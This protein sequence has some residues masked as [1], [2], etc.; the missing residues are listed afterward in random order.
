MKH[1]PFNGIDVFLAI[2]RAGSLRAAAT[3]LGVGAPAVS[4]QLK[5]LEQTLG[6]SLLVRTTRSIKLTDAGRAL[7]DGAAPA[8]DQITEAIDDARETGGAKKGTIRLT[9]PWSAY[10]IV[11]APSLLNFQ[12]AYPDI[13]LEL[14]FN[15]A[16][17]DIV[18]GGFHAGIRLGDRLTTDMIAVRLTPPLIAAYSAAPEYLISAGTPKH[19]RDLLHHKCIRYRF[20]S[21]NRIAAWHFLENDQVFTVDP[22]ANLVFDSFQS[23]VQAATEGFGIGWSLRAV[24]ENELVDHSLES[25]L[26][27]FVTEHPPFYLYFPAQYRRLE[28]L[29]V[30]V[31]FFKSK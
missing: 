23:V 16:L 17:V 28:L 31:D 25:V 14:S 8:F 6:V 12:A 30:L 21:A 18:E 20:I 26:D 10:K 29:R 22:T 4:H 19:P 11:F 13:R 7:L 5:T 15:E 27:D 3:S 24:I 1:T 2:V 9:L